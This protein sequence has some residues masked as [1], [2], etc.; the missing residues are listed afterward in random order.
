MI[1][2]VEKFQAQAPPAGMAGQFGGQDVPA[3]LGV[4]DGIK[5]AVAL[6][7]TVA[8]SDCC[9]L[10]EGETG[11]GKELAARR[12]HAKSPRRNKPFIPV[13]CAGISETLFE[14]QFFGHVRGAFTGAEQSMLGLVRTAE[15]GTLLLDEVGDIPLNLQAKLLRTLQD[16]EVM[17]VGTAKP[18]RIETRFI[19]A[20]NR[21]LADDVGQ[22]RFRSDLYFRLNVIHICLPPLRQRVEDIQVLLDHFLSDYAKRRGGAHIRVSAEV[23][24]Q[25]AAYPW[26]GNVR[27][28]MSWVDRLYITGLAPEFLVASL[29][30]DAEKVGPGQSRKLPTLHDA[31]RSAIAGALEACDNNRTAAANVLG[32]HRGTLLRKITQ[33]GLA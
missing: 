9:V 10:I 23:R 17:P 5:R 24:R 2:Q 14:S 12:L 4:S 13:N 26:P 8:A 15:G 27:E 28:L 19:A 16:G 7:D 3:L 32:I 30:A 6:I 33:H 20:T 29:F 31:E 25:L 18:V 21:S 11:T 1:R 22:G